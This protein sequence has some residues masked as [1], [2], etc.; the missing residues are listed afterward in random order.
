MRIESEIDYWDDG[1]LTFNPDKIRD[2]FFENFPEAIFNKTNL[3]RQNIENFFEKAE[4]QNY[5]PPD[6]VID[7]K[8]KVAFQNGPVYKYE[9]PFDENK[10]IIVTLKRFGITF[11]ADFDFDEALEIRIIEFLKLLRYGKIISE[12]QTINFSEAIE[13]RNYWKLND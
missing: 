5:N 10:K 9:I 8:W 1:F 13:N 4:E 3:A 11:E 12:K 2:I 7:A 6:F